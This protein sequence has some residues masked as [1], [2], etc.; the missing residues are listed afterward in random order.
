MQQENK[1]ICWKGIKIFEDFCKH[2]WGIKFE[3]LAAVVMQVVV[4]WLVSC[5]LTCSYWCWKTA[6]SCHL[7]GYPRGGG[8]R[9]LWNIH[10]YIAMCTA[11][12]SRRLQSS[13]WDINKQNSLAEGGSLISCNPH[14]VFK[15]HTSILGQPWYIWVH[16]FGGV[17]NNTIM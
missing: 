14:A 1:N 10:N 6:C 4:F 13:S 9:L 11:L 15:L 2:Q 3:A 12:Y 7:Q 17:R 5:S 16:V 8:C